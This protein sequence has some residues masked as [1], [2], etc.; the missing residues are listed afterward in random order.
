MLVHVLG[1]VGNVKISVA[2]VRELLE[3]GVERFLDKVNVKTHWLWNEERRYPSKANFVSKVVKATDAVLGIFKVVVLD[4]AETIAP[5]VKEVTASKEHMTCPL[6]R[7][8]LLSMM[9]L[10]LWISP[11]RFPQA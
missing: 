4:K 9:D 6:Q 10:E 8:V 1:D 5:S 11:K 3:F 7:N 2:L